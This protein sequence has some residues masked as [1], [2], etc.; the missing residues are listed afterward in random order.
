M[1]G[2]KIQNY[3]IEELLGEG[4]MGAVYKATDT[5]LERTV[6]IKALHTHLT[7]D[8]VFLERFKNEARLAAKLSHPTIAQIYNFIHDGDEYFIVMEYIQGTPLDV[9]LR[10]NKTIVFNSAL[11]IIHKVLAGLSHAH[12]KTI[13]HRDI[14]P[15]NIMLLPNGD[16]K[17][18]DFGIAKI[19]GATKLTGIGKIIGTMEYMSPELLKGEEASIQSDLYATGITLYE[20]ITGNMPFK[21]NSEAQLLHQ[22][23][24]TKHT[25]P[26]PEIYNFD[27]SFLNVFDKVLHKN[28]SRRPA[29]SQEFQEI[30]NEYLDS[31]S[32]PSISLIPSFDKIKIPTINFGSLSNILSFDNGS[33]FKII[34]ILGILAATLFI[35]IEI[36]F[37]SKSNINYQASTVQTNSTSAKDPSVTNETSSNTVVSLK[38]EK[39]NQSE[40]EPYNNSPKT[41]NNSISEKQQKNTNTESSTENTSGSK[42]NKNKIITTSEP[43]SQKK[44]VSS[45][46]ASQNIPSVIYNEKPTQVVTEKVVLQEQKSSPVEEKKSKTINVPALDVRVRLAETISSEDNKKINDLVKMEVTS[47]VYSNSD[48][49]IQNGAEAFARITKIKPSGKSSSYLE[50]QIEKVKCINGT[51]LNLKMI[52]LGKKGSSTE[53]IIF[54]KGLSIS[55]NPKIIPQTIKI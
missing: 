50:I 16:V 4:G 37:N 5:Q 1:L 46:P 18:M 51:W 7:N 36:Y 15:G 29:S 8:P 32:S 54:Q 35:G 11:Q 45:T 24:N 41:A 12:Q 30:I 31:E 55:P 26:N 53:P 49:I 33:P 10:Q 48:L 19:S 17:L 14:K 21:A 44:D 13:L 6:A 20:M 27:S 43:Q 25:N 28:P 23:I 22:I 34:A 39:S 38:S 3:Q 42:L 52:P 47:S 2:R 9:Y 40:S